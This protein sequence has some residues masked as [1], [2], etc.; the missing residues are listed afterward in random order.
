MNFCLFSKCDN[1]EILKLEII[2]S[3][4]HQQRD[5][6]PGALDEPLVLSARTSFWKLLAGTHLHE[7]EMKSP[8]QSLR[9]NLAES[10]MGRSG[11][12]T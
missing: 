1:S 2:S 7:E 5:P 11:K 9:R 4:F 6:E 10:A 8:A 12:V 3:S